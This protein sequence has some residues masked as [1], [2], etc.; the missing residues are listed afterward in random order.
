MAMRGCPGTRRTR[1]KEALNEC[2]QGYHAAH[3]A[4]HTRGDGGRRQGQHFL[5]QNWAGRSRPLAVKGCGPGAHPRPQTPTSLSSGPPRHQRR[6]A[7]GA[8]SPGGRRGTRR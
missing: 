3:L 2:P 6:E 8:A 5:T 4:S 1:K 7:R